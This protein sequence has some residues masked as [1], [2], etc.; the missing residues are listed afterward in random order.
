MAF[1]SKPPAKKKPEVVKS[2][3]TR[4]AG[5]PTAPRGGRR[6]TE[7]AG[8]VATVTGT[9]VMPWAPGQT[10]FEVAEANPGLCAVLENAALHFASGQAEEARTL[11]EQGIESDNDAKL[12]SLAWLALFDLMQRDGDKAAFERL[13][14]RYLA[15]FESSAPAWEAKANAQVAP[16]AVG[17]YLALSGRLTAASAKQLEALKRAIA[18]RAQSTKLDLMAVQGFDDAGAR[19][20]ADAL[21]EARRARLGLQLQLGDELGPSLEKALKRGRAAGEGAWL[22][23]LEL[24]QWTND[25]A[26]FEDRAV[27][28]AVTFELSPPSWEPALVTAPTAEAPP[29]QRV[30]GVDSGDPEVLKWSGVLAGSIAPQLG[31]LADSTHDKAVVVVDMSEVE[32]IDFVC[33]GALLNVITRIETQRKVVQIVG[34]SPIVR[35][36]MLLLGIPPRNFVKKPQ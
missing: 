33:A 2:D 36:L 17:G 30:T 15:Q 29:K 11:L 3:A 14:M 20:L 24:L 12:S 1:F 25:L 9:S 35:A 31:K 22:L 8:G 28:F 4:R 32:R 26:T 16:R 23:S 21:A 19:L 10:F 7:P 18:R 27:D 13:S 5:S 34:A 6:Q